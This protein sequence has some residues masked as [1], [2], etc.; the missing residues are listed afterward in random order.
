MIKSTRLFND[1]QKPASLYRK[2]GAPNN[3]DVS[4]SVY[5][6]NSLNNLFSNELC[7][8]KKFINDFMDT[9]TISESE[10]YSVLSEQ[11]ILRDANWYWKINYV[12]AYIAVAGGVVAFAVE[13]FGSE[14]D[15]SKDTKVI[16]L[17]NGNFLENLLAEAAQVGGISYTKSV[18][19]EFIKQVKRYNHIPIRIDGG[20]LHE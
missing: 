20:V 14:P 13:V 19:K 2:H 16:K 11:E 1:P 5:I 17:S 12:A 18:A 3:F 7:S 15:S 6:S 10:A 8:P 4:E 9:H